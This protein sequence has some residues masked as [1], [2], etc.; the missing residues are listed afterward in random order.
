MNNSTFHTRAIHTHLHELIKLGLNP[1]ESECLI[2]SKTKYNKDFCELSFKHDFEIQRI[3]QTN[4]AVTISFRQNFIEECFSEAYDY[5]IVI[6]LS[7]LK[8]IIQ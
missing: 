6:A 4:D 3:E 1:N 2:E 7:K 8:T 5:D